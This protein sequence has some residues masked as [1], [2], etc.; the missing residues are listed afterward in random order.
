MGEL[1]TTGNKFYTFDQNNSGGSF[2]FSDVF[3]HFMIIEAASADEANEIAEG[4]GIYFNGCETGEDC[5]C[6]G[7][8]W[9][10]ASEYDADE[11]PLICNKPPEDYSCLWTPKKKVICR[12]FYKN[13]LVKEYLQK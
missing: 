1:A 5:S 9:H 2:E 12:V 8:R 4:L 10:Q 7:D 11:T 3:A 6:C 13:G